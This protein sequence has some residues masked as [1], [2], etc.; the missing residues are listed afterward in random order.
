[1]SILD[2]FRRGARALG[3]VAVG[4]GLA[5][6]RQVADAL[7]EQARRRRRGEPHKR[8]GEILVERAVLSRED[9]ER[10]L[11][12]QGTALEVRIREAAGGV[13]VLDLAGYVDGETHDVLETAFTS[14]AESGRTRLVVDCAKLTYMSSNGVGALIS[15]ARGMRQA[16]GDIKFVR[17]HGKAEAVFEVLGLTP[18][19]QCFA[20]E[21][22]ALTAF[23]RPIPE[24]L[25]V[26]PEYPFLASK[27]SKFFHAAGCAKGKGIRLK[28]RVEYQ[29]REEAEAAGKRPCPECCAEG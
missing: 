2:I 7:A 25:Y 18:L 1:M 6:E 15:C 17:L 16:G 12:R 26:E 28:N 13:C 5:T 22:E 8:L 29:S 21:A 10:L 27:G 23:E 19:F 9:V 4:E 3:R 14:L 24:E 20:S 11:V